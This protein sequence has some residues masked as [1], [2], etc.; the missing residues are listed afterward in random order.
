[1]TATATRPLYVVRD[2]VLTATAVQLR[3]VV[4]LHETAGT[5][6][7]LSTPRLTEDGRYRVRL[8]LVERAPAPAPR[9]RSASTAR[10]VR[11]TRPRRSVRRVAV[12]TGAVTAALGGVGYLLLIALRHLVATVVTHLP[13]VLV[14]LAVLLVLAGLLA[15][16][17]ATCSGVHCGGCRHH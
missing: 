4:R 13:A 7:A 2:H 17:K 16:G 11:T 8:R 6:V 12:T 9:P 1:M 10:P 5:L 14:A 15:G 3:N